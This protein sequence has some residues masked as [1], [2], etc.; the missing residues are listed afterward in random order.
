[1]RLNLDARNCLRVRRTAP[2]TSLSTQTLPNVAAASKPCP[3]P[4][5]VSL[6]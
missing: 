2:T 6:G 5:S 3:L 1:M 4:E